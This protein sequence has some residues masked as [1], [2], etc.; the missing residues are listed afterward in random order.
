MVWTTFGWAGI[1]LSIPNDWEISGISGDQKSGYLRLDDAEMPRLELKWSEDKR[2]RG[3]NKDDLHSV[4]DEYFK[5]VRKSYRRKGKKKSGSN[6]LNIKREVDFFKKD[7]DVPL[8]APIFFQWRGDIFA[9]GVIYHCPNSK[10][11]TIAQVMGQTRQG[12]RAISIPLFLSLKNLTTGESDSHFLWSAYQM[13]FRTPQRYRLE[14]QQL[15]SGY[16][17]FSF[18]DSGPLLDRKRRLSV[19]RY[20]LADVLLKNCGLEDWF[21]NQYRK[22]LQGFGYQLK[23][24]DDG[25]DQEFILVGQENRLSDNIP[26]QPVQNLDRLQRRKSVAAHVRLCRLSNRIFVVQSVSKQEALPVVNGVASSICCH[27][28]IID[29]DINTELEDDTDPNTV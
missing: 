25:I 13:S 18:I 27:S 23:K 28:D 8:H 1:T 5:L 2:R 17:L 6:D 21:R 19:E 14:K 26:L 12:L 29:K 22:S 10:R 9:H 24:K 16:L 20:G 15:L 3:V 11:I 7:D 4:L